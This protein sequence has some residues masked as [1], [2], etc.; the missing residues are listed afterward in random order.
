MILLLY[1]L[2]PMLVFGTRF[3]SAPAALECRHACLQLTG[4]DRAR[5]A[6]KALEIKH[7]I[8]EP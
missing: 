3:H 7:P 6:P 4:L 8:K 2:A 1:G 5:K